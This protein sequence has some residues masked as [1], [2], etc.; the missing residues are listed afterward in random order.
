MKSSHRL[1]LTPEAEDDIRS[2]LEYTLVTWGERQHDRYARR[3]AVTLGDLARFPYLG[4]SRDELAPG[5]RSH[6]VGE[7]VV[8]Y[9]VEPVSITILRVLHR[10]MDA[11]TALGD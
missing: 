5:L 8:Y 1:I 4:R 3:I 10:N 7:H 2:I 11:T 9:R 6:P